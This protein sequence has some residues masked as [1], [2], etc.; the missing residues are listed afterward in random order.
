MALGRLSAGI[1]WSRRAWRAY[2]NVSFN[3]NMLFRSVCLLLIT[4]INFLVD[5]SLSVFQ[6]RAVGIFRD[7][8]SFCLLRFACGLQIVF[9]SVEFVR[10][11]L[12]E[13]L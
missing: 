4:Y 2:G 12:P 8:A 10:S 6:N 5:G 7:L 13:W 11:N 3:I 9:L 1:R